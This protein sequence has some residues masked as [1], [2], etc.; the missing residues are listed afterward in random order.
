MT[1]CCKSNNGLFK[2]GDDLGDRL[3]KGNHQLFQVISGFHNSLEGI[4]Q[5]MKVVTIETSKPTRK[6]KKV[7]SCETLFKTNDGLSSV[8]FVNIFTM[9]GELGLANL[10]KKHL[11]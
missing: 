8:I 9:G 1:S 11:Q 7:R 10:L 3:L 6:G 2:V 4:L 5:L